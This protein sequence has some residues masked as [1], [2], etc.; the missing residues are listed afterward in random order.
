MVVVTMVPVAPMIAVV[1]LRQI[2]N[3]HR[4]R[5]CGRGHQTGSPNDVGELDHD[6]TPRLS[7]HC[8]LEL[9]F[10]SLLFDHRLRQQARSMAYSTRWLFNQP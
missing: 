5:G 8:Q 9:N 10:F 1:C 7:R 6:L 3:T 2:W 4:Q